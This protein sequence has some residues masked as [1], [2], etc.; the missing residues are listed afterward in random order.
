MNE[1]NRDF[2]RVMHHAVMAVK[3]T[4][5]ATEKTVMKSE[6]PKAGIKPTLTMPE[7]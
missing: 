7:V 5:A 2:T 4:I 3:N 1:L 6:Y